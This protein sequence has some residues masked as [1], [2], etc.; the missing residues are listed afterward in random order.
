MDREAE[1]HLPRTRS[2]YKHRLL[3]RIGTLSHERVEQIVAGLR[4]LQS[5]HFRGR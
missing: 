1:N 3:E 5:S 4:L 2:V